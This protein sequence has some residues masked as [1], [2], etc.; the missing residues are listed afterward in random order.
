MPPEVQKPS[1]EEEGPADNQQEAATNEPIDVASLMPEEVGDLAGFPRYVVVVY[2]PGT[3]HTHC[4]V[5]L[6]AASLAVTKSA[7]QG[8]EAI[9]VI[10]EL[11]PV[12]I[13]LIFSAV[14]DGRH[15]LDR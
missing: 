11:R 2:R 9:P 14:R 4:Y 6:R 1:S 5:A 10:C 3:G 12:A 15:D 8:V 7:R 13:D